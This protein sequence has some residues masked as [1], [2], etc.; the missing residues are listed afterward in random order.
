MQ[1]MQDG[2]F[3]D[4]PRIYWWLHAIIHLLASFAYYGTNCSKN[5]PQSVVSTISTK[6]IF[7][8]S[9]IGTMGSYIWT[10]GIALSII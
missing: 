2:Q 7:P 9:Y 10:A 4:I 5:I 1:K 8:V 3:M 6:L